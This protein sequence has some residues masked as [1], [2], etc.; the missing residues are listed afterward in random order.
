MTDA[1]RPAAFDTIDTQLAP[2]LG[3]AGSVP[4]PASSTTRT[5]GSDSVP[6]ESEDIEDL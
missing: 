5:A 1:R 6:V 4:P 2:L 3:D